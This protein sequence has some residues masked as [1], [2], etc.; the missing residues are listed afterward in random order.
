MFRSS[1]NLAY[2]LSLQKA[3]QISKITFP[4]AEGKIYKLLYSYI[5]HDYSRAD[6]GIYE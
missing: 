3:H 6:K 5:I 4:S 2:F 1:I